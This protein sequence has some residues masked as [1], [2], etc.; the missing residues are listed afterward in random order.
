M[1]FE[2]FLTSITW[3]AR[4]AARFCGVL[5]RAVF[6]FA[7]W[8]R[9]ILTTLAPVFLCAVLLSSCA[10]R[11][12]YNKIKRNWAR[13][14]NTLKEHPQLADSIGIM[15]TQTITA[16]EFRD[17]LVYKPTLDT[18]AIDSLAGLLYIAKKT[19]ALDKM[20][21]PQIREKLIRATC[22]EVM[23]DSTFEVKFRVDDDT[24]KFPLQV[25]FSS[26]TGVQIHLPKT[27][28]EIAHKA[29]EIK[30][31]EPENKFFASGWF[32]AFVAMCVFWL[33]TVFFIK[34]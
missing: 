17:S 24:I 13:I 28:W 20:K 23:I 30:F 32:W 27:S 6:T 2:T 29:T 26:K 25:L 7:T 33:L 12:A 22:P 14:E 21:P 10:E 16:L 5:G 19:A 31:N 11:I 1:N 18:T 9:L 15:K 8:T 4:G 34:R 3:F